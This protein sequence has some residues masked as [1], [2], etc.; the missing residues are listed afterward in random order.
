MSR[1]V[2][3]LRAQ[4]VVLVTLLSCCSGCAVFVQNRYSVFGFGAFETESAEQ[5]RFWSLTLLVG[6]AL[7]SAAAGAACYWLVHKRRAHRQKQG[8]FAQ[9]V[10]VVTL[11]AEAHRETYETAT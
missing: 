6:V 4:V 5:A 7:C 9:G 11:S 8:A 1:I 10:P 2:R 3:A